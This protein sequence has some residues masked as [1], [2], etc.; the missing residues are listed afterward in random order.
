MSVSSKRRTTK[1]LARRLLLIY[2]GIFLV[3]ILVWGINIGWH[4]FHLFSLAKSLQAESVQIK[5]DALLPLTKDAAGDVNVIY[6]QL[7][8]LF[9]IFNIFQGLPGVGPYLGQIE[10]VLSY[11]NWLA[12]AGN[13][14]ALGLDPLLHES[15]PDQNSLSLPER[16]TQVLQSGQAHFINAAQAI[17]H[18]NQVRSR[19]QPVLFPATL[20]TQYEKLDEKFD[21]LQAGVQILQVAPTLLGVDLSPKLPDSGS[22]PR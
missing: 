5:P 11:A 8:P 16:I 2:L 18:A 9:P 7:N 21:L 19:I 15:T 17:D 6:Q 20:R 22:E 12:E 14:L 4:A 3:L 13:E 10:P 1:N